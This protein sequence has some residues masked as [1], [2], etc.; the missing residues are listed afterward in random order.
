MKHTFTV[1]LSLFLLANGSS[2]TAQDAPGR[3]CSSDAHQAELM[4]DP[5]YAAEHQLRMQRMQDLLRERQNNRSA[6]CAE[7]V[8]LPMAFHF[9]GFAN[10]DVECLRELAIGQL[11]ILN[12][13]YQGI[14][15]DIT[16]WT[17]GAATF[18]PGVSNG[19]SCIQFCLPTTGH[20]TGFGIG[21]GDPAVTINQ[22]TGSFNGSWSGYINVFVRNIGALGFSPLGGSG[23]G[24]GVTVDNQAFG[25]GSGCPGA[26]PAA[27]YNLGRTLTHELGHYLGLGHIWGGGCGQD[28][29]VGDTPNSSGGYLGCPTNGTS[30][31]GSTDMH[32]NYMDYVDDQ[33][34]YMFSAGQVGVMDAYASANLQNVIDNATACEDDPGG[35]GGGGGPVAMPEVNFVETFVIVNEGT[36]DCFSEDVRTISAAISISEA[37]D[38]DAEVTVAAFG[39]A[40]SGEDFVLLNSTVVFPAGSTDDQTVE[41]EIVEDLV[42][43]GN[44]SIGLAFSLNANGGNAEIGDQSTMEI[45]LEDDDMEP[46]EFVTEVATVANID[47]GF[48][49]FN[50]GP[51]A[52]V[53]FFDQV[54]GE[55]MLTIRNPS[56]HDYGCTY[57]SIDR[58]N[59]DNPGAID[60]APAQ[61]A[62]VTDKTYFISPD[63][64]N[65]NNTFSVRLY[66]TNAE[67]NGFL[68]ETG[69]IAMDVRMVKSGTDIQS[70]QNDMEVAV[71]SFGT[72]GNDRFYEATFSSGISGFAI[73]VEPMTLPVEFASFTATAGE[74]E[75]DLDWV[76]AQEENNQGFTVMRRSANDALFTSL[77]WIDALGETEG[78]A[79]RFTDQTAVAGEQY[80]YQLRQL[81]T[82]GTETNSAIVSARLEGGVARLTAYPNPV[83]NRLEVGIATSADGLLRLT[84]LDGRTLLQREFDGGGTSTS[85]D[86]STV[87]PG[88]YL[89]LVE[90]K[91]ETLVRKVIRK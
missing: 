17:D 78:G 89:L 71:P 7:S 12:D 21:D 90:T 79:Y 24:D 54:T 42:V 73:G 58:S 91:E 36:A 53:H 37:P 46:T 6:D 48:A 47:E 23:T 10:P 1:L 16:L 28:D 68:A 50:L 81:D 14:N 63:N 8:P 83:G 44:E 74:K 45:L 56:N 4:Q 27:P 33:C 11:Q 18:F 22:F 3:D 35:G 32:M 20:P 82:D 31:C 80:F 5:E 62:Q 26:N 34:M 41:L 65:F 52:T 67:I 72:F 60:V 88:V 69:R 57:V 77:G 64:N 49:N 9:Q 2:L 13:D 84:A 40:L 29:G 39:T 51:Q 70:E 66:Y 25:A 30:S 87:P 59:A 43:E 19:E 38:V 15:G 76:T 61:V 86:L 55:I 85:L 75:I